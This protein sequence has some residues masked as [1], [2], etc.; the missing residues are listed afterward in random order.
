MNEQRVIAPLFPGNPY[1]KSVDVHLDPAA[2]SPV[3]LTLTEAIGPIARAPD[4][5]WIK[6]VRIKSKILWDFWGMPMTI[7]AEELLPKD[8]DKNPV[9]RYSAIYTYGDYGG[10]LNIT[11]EHK[12]D[13]GDKRR[14]PAAGSI[15]TEYHNN[16]E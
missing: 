3:A 15:K 14:A 8:L 5:P 2:K 7:G 13:K 4:T 6:R 11:T 9:A 1:S 16:G 10:S 12:S